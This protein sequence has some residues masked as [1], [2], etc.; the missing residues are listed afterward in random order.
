MVKVIYPS[1][2]CAGT[3]KAVKNISDSCG[4]QAKT[5]GI[6]LHNVKHTDSSTIVTIYTRLFGKITYLVYNTQKKNSTIRTALLTPLSI[7]ELDVFHRQNREIQQ[8][9]ESRNIFFCK[10]IPFSPIK[11]AIALF[12]AEMLF[13]TLKQTDAD[14]NLFTFLVDSIKKLDEAEKES[15]NFH[16]V[17]LTKFTGYLGFEM[18]NEYF[19]TQ[20]FDLLNGMFVEQ[21]PEHKHFI[22]PPI[23]EHFAMLL[24]V[25]YD[26]MDSLKF[27]R[28]Q[29]IQ[30]LEY[31]LEYYRLHIANFNQIHSLSVLQTLFD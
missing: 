22:A 26:T 29:R 5:Y 10:N 28:Q 17:F 21:Q 25:D 15:V 30:L 1:T 6:V 16:L 18:N 2:Y 20:H 24:N 12:V 9:K 14:E 4:M 8:I 11:N 19:G 3:K 13:R 7:I 27:S 23:S 31:L